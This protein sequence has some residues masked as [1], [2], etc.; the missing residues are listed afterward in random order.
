[1]HVSRRQEIVE[2][3]RGWL[4]TKWR[5]QGRSKTGIDCAGL[6]V[7]VGKELALLDPSVDVLDYGRRTQG[8][9]LLNHLKRN[10]C[11]SR[12]ADIKDG[13]IVSFRSPKFPCHIGI[14][15]TKHGIRHII[16]AS[17]PHRRV[18]EEHYI[19]EFPATITHCFEYCGVDQWLN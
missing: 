15:S 16:H 17:I 6:I 2:H 1:M 7:Q 11:E 5:H 18:V 3:A 12:V 8:P 14:L 9:E 19:N 4:Q 13:S 10:L